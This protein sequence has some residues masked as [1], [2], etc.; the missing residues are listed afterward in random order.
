MVVLLVA[1]AEG[2][3]HVAKLVAELMAE[4]WWA[5]DVQDHEERILEA[6]QVGRVCWWKLPK[7]VLD[8]LEEVGSVQ[9]WGN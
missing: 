7:Q 9:V 6:L 2:L 5:L 3:V 8:D 1:S 4:L